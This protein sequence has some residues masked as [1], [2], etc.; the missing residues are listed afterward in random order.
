MRD[1]TA[2]LLRSELGRRRRVYAL[3]FGVFLAATTG[4]SVLLGAVDGIEDS[5]GRGIH[6]TVSADHR[7]TLVK[8]ERLAEGPV[9]ENATA[10]GARIASAVPGSTVA[11]RIEFDAIFLHTDRYE[12]FEAGLVVGVDPTRDEAV[13]DVGR[14]LTRGRLLD[15]QNVWVGG[16]PYPQIVIGEVMLKSMNMSVYNGTLSPANVVNVT[17]GRLVANSSGAV[18]PVVREA[19]V[20]GVYESGILPLDRS[21]VFVHIETARELLRVNLMRDAATLLVV[22]APG[23]AD[24]RAAAE[25]NG[26]RS[27]SA[28][29]FREEYLKAIFSPVRAFARLTTLVVLA[30][31]AGWVTHV[32]VSAIAGDRLRLA[33]L[34]ALGLPPSLLVSPI[35]VALGIAALAGVALGLALGTL[36]AWLMSVAGF[37]APGLGAIDFVAILSPLEALLLGLAVLSAASVAALGAGVAMRRIPV[38]EALR[39]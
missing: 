33:V 32:V 36:I 21:V 3:L 26:F 4:L 8:P 23:G 25:A 1:A 39:R 19:V 24:V 17:A 11:P 37:R 20:V 31:S 30:I 14:F 16:K 15:G 7:L 9:F 22:D 12:D 27:A 35:A 18:R 10:T 5:I 2:L 6:D 29:E 34:R 28:E 38:T 13:V